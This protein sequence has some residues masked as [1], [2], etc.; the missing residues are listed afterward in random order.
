MQNLWIYSSIY[1]VFLFSFPVKP[2]PSLT[3]FGFKP[4]NPPFF[5]IFTPL[6][7]FLLSYFLRLLSFLYAYR[8][9]IE[10]S[11]AVCVVQPDFFKKFYIFISVDKCFFFKH[12]TFSR[13]FMKV[14]FTKM[15]KMLTKSFLK[16]YRENAISFLEHS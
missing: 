7:G 5:T 16:S 1:S 15:Y 9:Q 2:F 14:F 6:K 13:Q 3:L 12:Q 10:V 8:E 11:E 4:F